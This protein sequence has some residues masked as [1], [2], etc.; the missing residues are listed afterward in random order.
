MV[1]YCMTVSVTMRYQEPQRW[2]GTPVDDLF[3]KIITI[4]LY[5]YINDDKY[6]IK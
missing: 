1:T 5:C 6:E 3:Y 4:Y 2:I